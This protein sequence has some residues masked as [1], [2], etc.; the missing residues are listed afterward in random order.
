MRQRGDVIV[1]HDMYLIELKL[2]EVI[3]PIP[4]FFP[5]RNNS[6]EFYESRTA[7]EDYRLSVR[8]LYEAFGTL[9]IFCTLDV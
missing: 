8:V 1:L 3:N 2:A 9:S 6:P 4:Q 7:E 5:P